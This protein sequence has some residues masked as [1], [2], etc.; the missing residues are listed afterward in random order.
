MCKVIMIDKTRND[1]IFSKQFAD[2]TKAEALKQCIEKYVD[3]TKL[4]IKVEEIKKKKR[5]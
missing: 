5:G 1:V 4:E 3:K 2:R